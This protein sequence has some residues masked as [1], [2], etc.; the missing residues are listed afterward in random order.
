MST[1]FVDEDHL[2]DNLR[3]LRTRLSHLGLVRSTEDSENLRQ[4]LTNLTKQAITLRYDQPND[5]RQILHSGRIHSLHEMPGN[6]EEKAIR[7][8]A[9]A[10][11]FGVLHENTPG[12]IYGMLADRAFPAAIGDFGYG[13]IRIVLRDTVHSRS[14]LTRRDSLNTLSLLNFDP[15]ASELIAFPLEAL[16]AE[17]IPR[18]ELSALLQT[19]TVTALTELIS[20][21]GYLE[22][23]IHGGVTVD[24]IEYVE[25]RRGIILEEETA[26]WLRKRNLLRSAPI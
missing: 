20:P 11:L 2:Q 10:V 13:A 26:Q 9:E 21:H 3:K 15:I 16:E 6:L 22:V 1:P 4:H 5:L 23:Q 25:A 8:Q 18:C 12:P 14:T 17:L 19:T 24:D 7:Q